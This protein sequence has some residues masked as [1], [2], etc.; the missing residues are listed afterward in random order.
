LFMPY[1]WDTP[2]KS[3]DIF[4]YKEVL[5]NDFFGKIY[6]NI[7]DVAKIMTLGSDFLVQNS[8]KVSPFWKGNKADIARVVQGELRDFFLIIQ[9]EYK[10]AGDIANEKIYYHSSKFKIQPHLADRLSSI[11]ESING[12][13]P[14]QGKWFNVGEH[15]V[16][17]Y[18]ISKKE[19]LNR[20]SDPSVV[21]SFH[22][23][24][25]DSKNILLNI[26]GGLL[27]VLIT[28]IF[29]R[30]RRWMRQRELRAVFGN[31][32]VN[33][34]KAY[35]VYANFR[36][37]PGVQNG[38]RWP[39]EKPDGN[40]SNFSIENPVSG[41]EARAAN[42]PISVLS[43]EGGR[44]PSFSPDTQ[45]R[46][47]VDIS[48]ISLG[49]PDSNYKTDDANRNPGN[50][51][52]VFDQPNGRMV[53]VGTSIPL[54]QRE[55]GFDYGLILKIHPQQHPER[56]WIVCAGFDE[57]GSS[58]AAYYLSQNWKKIYRRSGS[59][60]FAIIVKVRPTQDDSAEPIYQS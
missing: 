18:T 2:Q 39:Y 31:D 45:V 38:V 40:G 26:L 22:G 17:R 25:D 35:I 43:R 23:F 20:Q 50:A 14:E 54:F 9:I 36:L 58:G 24:S 3:T 53:R 7:N 19:T 12:D 48:F 11:E 15:G 13:T 32:I 51:L 5:F 55:P 52:V 4:P 29:I 47:F 33:A 59:A 57:W 6:L 37:R 60:S 28:D 49:G 42:Y 10:T 44:F 8:D 27:T 21:K 41:C 56:V 1:P 34:V 46:G 30:I 16:E